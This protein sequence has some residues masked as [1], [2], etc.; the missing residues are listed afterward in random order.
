[1][2]NI[3]YRLAL[4]LATGFILAASM[5]ACSGSDK[6]SESDAKAAVTAM[7]GDCQYLEVDDFKR[8]NG[9]PQQDGSYVV[10]ANYSVRI[11]PTG[12]V[13]DFVENEYR[14][15]ISEASSNPTAINIANE[16]GMSRIVTAMEQACPNASQ[17]F[18][19]HALYSI[20]SSPGDF[21]HDVEVQV[22]N[23]QIHMIK[24]DN[25]WQLAQ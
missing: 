14:S 22:T 20:L 7:L 10:Q 12:D 4:K 24:T 21:D 3:P 23:A 13:K 5:T 6:P 9:I 2:N 11:T 17:R 8:D 25:G 19:A 16:Q 15:Q 18:V 1:M